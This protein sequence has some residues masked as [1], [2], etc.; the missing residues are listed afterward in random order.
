MRQR[1]KEAIQD[2][3]G[4]WLW[5]SHISC[6]VINSGMT[7]FLKICPKLNITHIIFG[8]KNA[9]WSFCTTFSIW[10]T[11]KKQPCFVMQLIQQPRTPSGTSHNTT[12]T[13]TSIPDHKNDDIY[14]KRFK[15]R[16]VPSTTLSIGDMNMTPVMCMTDMVFF[17]VHWLWRENERLTP[18]RLAAS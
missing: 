14:I 16:M 12:F 11:S 3:R 2:L 9:T 7:S 5:D 13:H 10:T 18:A 4:M 8:T 15:I 17:L 1:E 6:Y